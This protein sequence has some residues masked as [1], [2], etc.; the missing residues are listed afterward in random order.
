MKN[1]QSLRESPE[2]SMGAGQVLGNRNY[3]HTCGSRLSR[4]QQTS[5]AIIRQNP[6][7]KLLYPCDVGH[8]LSGV[9]GERICAWPTRT[10]NRR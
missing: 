8:L 10:E 3:C 1:S 4:N 9:R 7:S 2:M 6:Y 5:R